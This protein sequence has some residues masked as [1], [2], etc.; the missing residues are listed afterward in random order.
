MT[1][2]L[3]LVSQASPLHENR[4]VFIGAVW[5]DHASIAT[6]A[7]RNGSFCVLISI[8]STFSLKG[9]MYVVPT[10]VLKGQSEPHSDAGSKLLLDEC[11]LY[12]KVQARL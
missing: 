9:S 4:I 8:H 2:L 12:R 10:R 7:N 6:I 11:A 3:N 5:Q 1:T